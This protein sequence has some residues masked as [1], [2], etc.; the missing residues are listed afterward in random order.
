MIFWMYY[1]A[2][3]EAKFESFIFLQNLQLCQLFHIRCNFTFGISCGL[4][5]VTSC[6]GPFKLECFN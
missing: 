2:I 5:P 6:D 3:L 1:L 4:P